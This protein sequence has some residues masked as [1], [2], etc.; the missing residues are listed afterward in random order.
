MAPWRIVK[1]KV[2]PNY[3]LF[4]TFF[5]GVSGAV[6]MRSLL[7]QRNLAG[8]VFEPLQEAEFFAKASLEH[9]AVTWPNGADLAPDAMH[10]E[11]AKHGVWVLRD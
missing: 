2:Q 10:E 9:G 5:D 3:Q 7:T 8:T 6:D 1:L 11:I 4:V